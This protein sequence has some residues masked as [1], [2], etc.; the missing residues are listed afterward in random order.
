ME[1]FL[2]L[3]CVVGF[4]NLDSFIIRIGCNFWVMDLL[5]NLMKLWVFFRGCK[6]IRIFID[7]ILGYL[8]VFGYIIIDYRLCFYNIFMLLKWKIGFIYLL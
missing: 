4:M 1:G 5:G 8:K 3:Y 2:L 7:K 6:C